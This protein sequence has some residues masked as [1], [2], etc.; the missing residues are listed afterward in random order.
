MKSVLVPLH[1]KAVRGF[2]IGCVVG[3][4]IFLPALGLLSSFV[5]VSDEVFR[6]FFT[7]LMVLCTGWI[8]RIN[9]TTFIK[10]A[11]FLLAYVSAWY[12]VSWALTLAILTLLR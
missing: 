11:A 9:K 10:G 12:A 7:L 2:L 8:F 4:V 6:Q 5:C 3:I 1:D